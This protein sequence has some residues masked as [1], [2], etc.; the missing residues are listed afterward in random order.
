MRM[1]MHMATNQ[2]ETKTVR[3]ITL[4]TPL[5]KREAERLAEHAGKSVGQFV[6]DLIREAMNRDAGEADARRRG[7]GR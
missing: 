7:G 2:E 1:F 4:V 3:L 5:M 6:R